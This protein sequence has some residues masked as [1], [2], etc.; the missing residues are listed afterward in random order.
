MCIS[1]TGTMRNSRAVSSFSTHIRGKKAT[2]KFCCT[3]SR[4]V[5]IVGISISIFNGT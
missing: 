5:S 2:P 1:S 3:S 4:I